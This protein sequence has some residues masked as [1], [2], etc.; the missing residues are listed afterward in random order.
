MEKW[1]SDVM[2]EV[3]EL[4]K[5]F[6][7]DML[8][9]EEVDSWDSLRHLELMYALEEKFGIIL[10]VDEIVEMVSFS[11]VLEMMKTKKIERT[12]GSE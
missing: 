3:L 5:D 6:P 12:V 7:V 4:D 10:D 1:I 9:M 2:R 11:K 8:T